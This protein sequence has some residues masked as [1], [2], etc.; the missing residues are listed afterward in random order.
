M[1][2]KHPLNSLLFTFMLCS[3]S[4][5]HLSG[6]MYEGAELPQSELA[7][8]YGGGGSMNSAK[9]NMTIRKINGKDRIDPYILNTAFRI[10]TPTYLSLKPG[11]HTL[12][13]SVISSHTRSPA[14]HSNTYTNIPVDLELGHTYYIDYQ[15]DQVKD[16]LKFYV[17][18]K[19]TEYDLTCFDRAIPLDG[20]PGLT[21]DCL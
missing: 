4:T 21:P 6:H 3:C 17:V 15:I 9:G 8:I 14:A 10:Y 16:E 5:H 1:K 11:K 12:T 20:Y 2:L 13:V 18:D 7:A 19:G